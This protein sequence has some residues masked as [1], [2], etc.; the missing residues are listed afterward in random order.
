MENAQR[1]LSPP[2]AGELV[3]SREE[4][5]IARRLRSFASALGVRPKVAGHP[6]ANV[7]PAILTGSRSWQAALRRLLG[8]LEFRNLKN[9]ATGKVERSACAE[10]LKSRFGPA[11]AELLIEILRDP[12][13][14]RLPQ[15]L[16]EVERDVFRLARTL[17]TY[18]LPWQRSSASWWSGVPANVGVAEAALIDR[19]CLVII[20]SDLLRRGELTELFTRLQVDFTPATE[21]LLGISQRPSVMK[22]V[23]SGAAEAEV[24]E[25]VSPMLAA[26]ELL[27]G[28]SAA[29]VPMPSVW[30]L[31]DA[32]RHPF[33]NWLQCLMDLLHVLTPSD[34]VRQTDAAITADSAMR[35][36][37]GEML[38]TDAARR[39]TTQIRNSA[40]FM[41]AVPAA[42]ALAFAIEF[43]M[44]A[45][46][47]GSVGADAARR[48]I[49]AR[50]RDMYFDVQ[51]AVMKIS[52]VRERA[53]LAALSECS[54]TTRV[55]DWSHLSLADFDHP[56][57][58]WPPY[59]AL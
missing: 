33:G 4:V 54:F 37:R 14:A 46:A 5:R 34:L 17:H 27:L 39:L 10:D 28:F 36:A 55:T 1:T 45:D 11:V 57:Y 40:A 6:S 20:G 53:M 25:R 16:R 18:P 47:D 56:D 35:Y 23:N 48:I 7:L 52:R 24:I 29:T 31:A 2:A 8:D 44:A 12:G 22:E 15:M 30:T 43:L 50:I 3:G 32:K 21:R 58:R 42:R 59:A 49:S 9:Y 51:V 38:T 26:I 13:T 41:A 19:T